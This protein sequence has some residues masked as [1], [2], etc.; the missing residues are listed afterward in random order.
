MQLIVYTLPLIQKNLTFSY[1]PMFTSDHSDQMTLGERF[2]NLIQFF[3][4]DLNVM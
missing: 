4:F 3:L 1:V 2:L